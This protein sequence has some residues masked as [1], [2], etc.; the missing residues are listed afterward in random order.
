MVLSLHRTTVA[1]QSFTASSTLPVPNV[2]QT[3]RPAIVIFFYT[4]E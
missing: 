1:T 2:C 4:R 3:M